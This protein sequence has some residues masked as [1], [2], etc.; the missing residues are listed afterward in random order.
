MTK[1]DWRWVEN[2]LVDLAKGDG[3]DIDEANTGDKVLIVETD[4]SPINLTLIAKEL[5][6][7]LSQ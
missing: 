2:E 1:I 3:R 6:E 4:P 5:A 7:R